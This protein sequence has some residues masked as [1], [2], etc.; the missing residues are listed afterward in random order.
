MPI[1]TGKIDEMEGV[2]NG[3]FKKFVEKA[4]ARLEKQ[5]SSY[6]TC[7]KPMMA[8]LYIWFSIEA[9][10]LCE[11]NPK[12]SCFQTAIDGCPKFKAWCEKMDKDTKHVQA[13]RPEQLKKSPL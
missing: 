12:R 8:D 4:E 2:A 6:L 10:L 11:N 9:S 7:D 3:P 5:N 1:F 13:K